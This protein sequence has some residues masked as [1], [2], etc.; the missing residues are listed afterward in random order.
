[1]AVTVTTGKTHVKH[2]RVLAGGV[3]ISGDMRTI[4]PIGITYEPVVSNGFGS[5]II[6]H[7]HGLATL[8]GGQVE[9]LYNGAAAANGV[10]LGSHGAL[11][12]QDDII[13][14]TVLGIGEAPTIG[15]PAFSAKVSQ[16]EYAI[17][18]Q[19]NDMV[20]SSASFAA[21]QAHNGTPQAVW[22]QML[23]VGQSASA[24][25]EFDSL[26]GG[27]ASTGCI[28][29]L[30]ITQSEGSMAAN[31][32]QVRLQDSPDDSTWNTLLD[33]TD[34]QAS[35]TAA[36]WVSSTVP[37]DRYVRAIVT[38]SSGTDIVAWINFVRL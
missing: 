24:T 3:N 27:A 22:G 15:A 23:A 37:V 28:A 38:K 2:V 1:M 9:T 25:T 10:D 14:T 26:D 21:R 17:A 16:F 32:W 4:S 35:A 20:V 7:T 11:S 33:F 13:M 30:H 31:N 5:D 19:S 36:V 18:A 29:V 34:D 12:S 8:N 6:S